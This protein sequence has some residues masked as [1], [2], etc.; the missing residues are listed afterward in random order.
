ML[1]AYAKRFWSI[2]NGEGAVQQLVG[3]S[4]SEAK[5]GWHIDPVLYKSELHFRRLLEKLPAGAYTCDADG[6][7]TYFNERAA[8]LWGRAPKLNDPADRF[9]GSFKLY[10][11]D[12]APLTHDQCWM[13][14]ALSNQREYNGK[15]V[16]VECPDGQRLT[17]LAHVNP[18]F[19]D[20]GRLL[21]AVNVLVDITERKQMETALRAAEQRAKQLNEEL[22]RRVA[23]RTAQLQAANQELESFAY[24]VSHDLQ[25]PL[26]AIEG[27]SGILVEEYSPRLEKDGLNYLERIRA[28]SRRMAELI[29]DLLQLS[30]LS[31]SQLQIQTVDLSELARDILDSLQ[32]RDPAR[33]L[34]ITVVP[35][36]PARA[37]GRL[38][39]IAL[40]N[41]LD[42]AWKFTGKQNHA[43]IEF[44]C[45]VAANDQPL[46]FVRDNGIGFDAA[47][48]DKL[49]NP[50]QRLH[51]ADEFPGTG[52]GLATVQRIIHRHN[53]R[54]W[55]EA[56]V[57]QG[58]TFYF[59]LPLD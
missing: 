12:G 9:C 17:M 27:F 26:R 58:A 47:Q 49:F 11:P 14:L 42:N 18:F 34:T 3:A 41:L 30:R 1:V 32:Q 21:G 4:L 36:S 35:Q 45:T 46:Y 38:L 25:T 16:V 33:R 57:N 53:G 19:D 44:G 7:I 51:T 29:D 39:R 52:I 15:E 2:V 55:V 37:D 40:E 28:A 50:F 59:T 20:E 6:L 43:R 10:L 54:I 48:G 24:S 56:A 5:N 22:E 23:E 8:Q 13:A 31:R